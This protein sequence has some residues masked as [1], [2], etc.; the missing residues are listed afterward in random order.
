VHQTSVSLDPRNLIKFSEKI[1]PNEGA[2]TSTLCEL[3]KN[4]KYCKNDA[5]QAQ[6]DADPITTDQPVIGL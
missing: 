6:N 1:N 5:D 2:F 3:I 4:Y